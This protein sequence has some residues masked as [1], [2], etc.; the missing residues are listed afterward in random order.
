MLAAAAVTMNGKT[1]HPIGCF[2]PALAKWRADVDRALSKHVGAFDLSVSMQSATPD[3]A[4]Q[5]GKLTGEVLRR[6][7]A[8]R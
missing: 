2:G 4:L 5:L 8:S 7:R 6:R 1:Y 3:V